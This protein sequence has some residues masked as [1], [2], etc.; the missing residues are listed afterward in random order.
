LIKAAL[1]A[2]SA[3]LNSPPALSPFAG[4]ASSGGLP[5][6]EQW[7][8]SIGGMIGSLAGGENIR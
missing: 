7:L 2:L 8:F 1:R 5:A 3:P 4:S 6:L